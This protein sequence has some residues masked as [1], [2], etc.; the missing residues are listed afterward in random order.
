[1]R[2]DPAR[3]DAT[4]AAFGRVRVA[5]EPRHESWFGDETRAVLEAHGAALCLTDRAGAKGPVWRTADWTYLRMHEG[6]A[7]PRPCYGRAAL[8]GW[9]RR[10]CE[11]WDDGED[12]YVFFNN[13]P[14]ACAP[15]DA[16]A[17]GRAAARGGRTVTR[18]PGPREVVPK[19]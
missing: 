13:D 5:V 12:V 6:C 17:F 10:L 8:A 7:S 15:R 16:A 14:R 18:V 4:L 11:G 19:G 1:M 9:V 2:A 3:L